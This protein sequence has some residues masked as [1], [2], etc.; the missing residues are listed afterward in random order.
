MNK[1]KKQAVGCL[2]ATLLACSAC[3]PNAKEK[4]EEGTLKVGIQVDTT[5]R[6]ETIHVSIPVYSTDS[7]KTEGDQR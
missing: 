1:R 2:L 3:A 7:L 6:Q 5:L 4:S